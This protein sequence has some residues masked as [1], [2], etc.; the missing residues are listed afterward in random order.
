MS[1]LTGLEAAALRLYGL[2]Q[3]DVDKIDAAIPAAESLIA[4][5]NQ[6]QPMIDGALALFAK[7]QPLLAQADAELKKVMP[8]AMAVRVFMSQRGT[9]APAASNIDSPLS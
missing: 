7:A 6:A 4:L 2:S 9:A 1:N 3:D 8:A 5:V